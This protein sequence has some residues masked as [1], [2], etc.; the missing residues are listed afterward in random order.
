MKYKIQD[1]EWI[2][3]VNDKEEEEEEEEEGR[4]EVQKVRQIKKRKR[5]MNLGFSVWEEGRW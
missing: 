3:K 5:K 2:V 1:N 4:S